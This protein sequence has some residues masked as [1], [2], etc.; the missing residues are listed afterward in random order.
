MCTRVY[1]CILYTCVV[2]VCMRICVRQCACLCVSFYRLVSFI[3]PSVLF[4][5]IRCCIY[6]YEPSKPLYLN[7]RCPTSSPIHR[8]H[9]SPPP[10]SL[11]PPLSLPPHPS[12][13]PPLS[14][15]MLSFILS[16]SFS[17]IL[18]IS[19]FNYL[20]SFVHLPIYFNK[21]KFSISL[22]PLS[23]PPHTFFISNS[24]SLQN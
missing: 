8:L 12:L 22:S 7:L 2:S 4:D 18:W 15:L 11:S 6:F 21:L 10:L 13:P 24:P 23:L 5:F 9:F 14:P 1:V 17:L 16:F 3:L 20:Y 19:V